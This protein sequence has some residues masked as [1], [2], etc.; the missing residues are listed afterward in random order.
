M[1]LTNTSRISPIKTKVPYIVDLQLSWWKLL[2]TLHYSVRHVILKAQATEEFQPCII[3]LRNKQQSTSDLKLIM[4]D[5]FN[6]S[7]ADWYPVHWWCI[8]EVLNFWE[9]NHI[10]ISSM[11]IEYLVCVNDI[12]RISHESMQ[13]QFGC[14]DALNLKIRLLWAHAIAM[15]IRSDVI[16]MYNHT[17]HF[18]DIQCIHTPVDT[19]DILPWHRALSLA[20]HLM[21]WDEDCPIAGQWEESSCSPTAVHSLTLLAK[22]SEDTSSALGHP[23]ITTGTDLP[24]HTLGIFLCYI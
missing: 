3:L 7:L 9:I 4:F 14:F 21:L 13:E 16:Y 20:Y 5:N 23:V 17:K 22:V 10:Q 15:T 19:P 12:H 24:L 1:S 18:V 6:Y 8:I 2:L 11:I